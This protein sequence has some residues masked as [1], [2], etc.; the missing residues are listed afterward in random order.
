MKGPKDIK[1]F[2][3]LILFLFNISG[4]SSLKP[5]LLR[6]RCQKSTSCLKALFSISIITINI[7]TSFCFC[8]NI[9]GSYFIVNA[10]F[11]PLSTFSR[12]VLCLKF[13][14]LKAIS[15]YIR[16]AVEV[17]KWAEFHWIFQWTILLIFTHIL[18][19]IVI[20]VWFI[21]YETP[22]KVCLPTE[23]YVASIV[24]GV[25]FACVVN[26]SLMIPINLFIVLYA[27]VCFELRQHIL[28]FV[29]ILK[30]NIYFDYEDLRKSYLSLK[31][32]T[33]YVDSKLSFL[34]FMSIIYNANIVYFIVVFLKS[35]AQELPNLILIW[36]CFWVTSISN[37]IMITSAALVGE[38][39]KEVWETAQRL[40]TSNRSLSQQ[41]FL[42]Y[43][44]HG[45]NLTVWKF[46]PISRALNLVTMGT[47]FTYILLLHNL[48]HTE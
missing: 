38:A 27:S 26:N 2:Y 48:D 14:Q 11:Y 31:R 30:T 3:K 8:W 43:C 22:I 12:C 41:R 47:I 19:A 37:V 1:A 20:S 34:V 13:H 39:S 15:N 9:S 45:L 28:N 10:I 44:E 17:K 35:S 42:S 18:T 6:K 36:I 5:L 32:V 25:I 23:N 7:V 33:T 24:V 21:F 29:K 46:V 16:N 40:P 4:I